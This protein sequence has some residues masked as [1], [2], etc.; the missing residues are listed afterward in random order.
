MKVFLTILFG[1]I[2]G[3]CGGMGLG[4]GTFLIPLF[5][6][7]DYGQTAIQAMNLLSFIPMAVIALYFHFKTKLVETGGTGWIIVPAVLFCVLG[8]VL[9]KDAPPK[10]LKICFGVFMAA[11][12]LWEITKSILEMKK[13]KREK[14]EKEELTTDGGD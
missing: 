7:L 14:A 12:G 4:G 5:Q 9:A 8:A 1:F 2:A 11:V 10:T 13:A 3:I 6:S